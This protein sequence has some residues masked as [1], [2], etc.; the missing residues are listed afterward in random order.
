VVRNAALCPIAQ[1]R[2]ERLLHR[3]L[4]AVEGA[5]Q[6]DQA[7]DDP[8]MLAAKYRFRRG[9]DFS[10]RCH[11]SLAELLPRRN[12][13]DRADLDAALVALARGRDL[14]GPG[15]RFVQVLAVEDVV[16]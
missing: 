10:R 7:G 2:G 16:S 14:C 12:V 13:G 1:R 11:W 9:E 8:A 3:L 15:D 4:G 5:A 6:P